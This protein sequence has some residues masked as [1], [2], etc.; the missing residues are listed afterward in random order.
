MAQS[1]IEIVETNSTLTVVENSVD[2]SI[3][4]TETTITL[5]NSGPQAPQGIQGELGPELLS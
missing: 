1:V 4:E 3:V 5:S 2:V